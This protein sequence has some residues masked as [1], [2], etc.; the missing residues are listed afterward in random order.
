MERKEQIRPIAGFGE[1]DLLSLNKK[2][3]E[4]RWEYY[5]GLLEDYK[6]K[7]IDDLR[8]I[9]GL[10]AEVGIGS[11]KVSFSPRL[12][13]GL[14]YYTGPV[15]ETSVKSPKIG[16]LVGGGRYDNLIGMFSGIDVP[17]TGFA[18]GLE[19]IIESIREN[20]TIEGVGE[21][22]EVLVVPF[23]P[24]ETGVAMKIARSLRDGGVNTDIYMGDDRIKKKLKYAD[25][26]GVPRVVIVA[27][28]EVKR[29]VVKI[30]DMKSGDEREVEIKI[31]A[32][33]IL[34]SVRSK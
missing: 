13:R 16:S 31:A 3:I 5:K 10:L 15:Y 2:E 19:R 1:Y 9:L 7:G 14:A 20:M 32:E 25:R 18:L 8:E 33:A 6:K 28:D 11:E 27:P 30:K 34:E 24:D 17:A 12:A 29:G 4:E 23:G 22:I 26:L 21:A